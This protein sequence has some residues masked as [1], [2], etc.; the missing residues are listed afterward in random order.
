MPDVLAH[1]VSRIVNKLNT[2]H[3][4]ELRI[5]CRQFLNAGDVDQVQAMAVDRLG[6]DLRVTKGQLTDEYR[7]G[8]RQKVRAPLLPTGFGGEE[9]GVLLLDWLVGC[10]L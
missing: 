1:D 5:M 8:F 6:M 3:E 4:V 2:E 10:Y 7:V 9:G